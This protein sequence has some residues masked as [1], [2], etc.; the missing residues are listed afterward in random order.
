MSVHISYS[1]SI[2]NNCASINECFTDPIFRN[3]SAERNKRD[4]AGSVKEEG[5]EAEGE[6]SYSVSCDLH[7]T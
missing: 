6:V 4:K 3:F 2:H 5:G 7:V 1:I